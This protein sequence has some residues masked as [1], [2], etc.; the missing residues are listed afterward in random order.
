MN[1]TTNQWSQQKTIAHYLSYLHHFGA[2]PFTQQ[3]LKKT[4]PN[5]NK[6]NNVIR[7][8]LEKNIITRT[9]KKINWGFVYQLNKEYLDKKVRPIDV[10]L[11]ARTIEILRLIAASGHKGL[12]NRDIRPQ[13]PIPE[14]RQQV[15]RRIWTLEEHKLIRM[16][17]HGPHSRYFATNLA[18]STL[19]PQENIEQ[20]QAERKRILQYAYHRKPNINWNNISNANILRTL[21]YRSLAEMEQTF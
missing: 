3:D 20:I 16:T 6:R 17:Y 15:I 5:I 13:L 21:G 8:A 9:N 14:S 19:F 12:R 1:K 18:Y 11:P 4:I 7:R 10:L 2:K